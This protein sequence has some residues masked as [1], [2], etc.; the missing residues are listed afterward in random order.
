MKN[1]KGYSTEKWV[2]LPTRKFYQAS[3][4][5]ELGGDRVVMSV[6]MPLAMKRKIKKLAVTTGKE[7]STLVREMLNHCLASHK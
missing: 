5:K 1:A 2:K 3:D 6:A 7:Q 4:E